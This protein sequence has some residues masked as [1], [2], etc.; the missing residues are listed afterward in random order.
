LVLFPHAKVE[1]E[2]ICPIV[3]PSTVSE[4]ARTSSRLVP[5][6]GS[7]ADTSLAAEPLLVTTTTL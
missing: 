5:A 2:E 1:V 4:A 3:L 6:A 7:V